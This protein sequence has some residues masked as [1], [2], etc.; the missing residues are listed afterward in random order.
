MNI[1]FDIPADVQAGVA[2]ISDLNLRV[3]LYLRHEARLEAVRRQ[4][5]SPEAREIVAE[6]VRKAEMDKA[7][8]FDWDESFTQL[9]QMR[10]DIAD[11]L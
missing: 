8:G 7:A 9:R 2:G 10:Q 4:R 3:A 6:A 5:H 11:R 1:T